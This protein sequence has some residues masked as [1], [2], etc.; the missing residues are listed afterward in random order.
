MSSGWLA[1]LPHEAILIGDAFTQQ[2]R[3]LCGILT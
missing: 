2:T 3:D 1:S